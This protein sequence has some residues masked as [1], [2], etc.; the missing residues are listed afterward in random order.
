MRAPLSPPLPWLAVSLAAGLT[1]ATPANAQ[2]GSA[3]SGPSS[4]SSAE[5]TPALPDLRTSEEARPADAA[6][7]AEP[8]SSESP[9]SEPALQ[10]EPAATK[11]DATDD[12][13]VDAAATEDGPAPDDEPEEQRPALFTAE[14]AAEMQR[15]SG[16]VSCGFA[17]GF[18]GT[19]STLGLQCNFPTVF[20][21]D[22]DVSLR[23]ITR[24]NSGDYGATGPY[25]PVWYNGALIVLRSPVVAGLFR[26]YGG[27]GGW[28]AWRPD[29]STNA[30]TCR[31]VDG[32]CDLARDVSFSGGGFS[33]IEFYDD[34]R[35]YFIEI[36][37][38]GGAHASRMDSGLYLFAGS[39]FFF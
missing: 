27:G 25:D 21:D 1:L 20:I 32:D 23:V 14:Y 6:S 33:G 28:L 37:A 13:D 8:P 35:G 7:S 39:N 34:L 22:A 3:G 4:E 18:G 17:F 2:E 12:G 11:T 30:E 16:R 19:G 29:P 15:R 31:H 9:P 5:T 10:S 26:F 38:Q 24:L 36:G